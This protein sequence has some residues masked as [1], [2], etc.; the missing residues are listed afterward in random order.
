MYYKSGSPT[1]CILGDTGMGV[2][3]EKRCNKMNN[4]ETLKKICEN[5]VNWGY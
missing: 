2:L 4:N 3:N 5:N 1:N